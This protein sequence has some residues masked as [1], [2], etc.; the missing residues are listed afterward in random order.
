[1]DSLLKNIVNSID[2]LVFVKN[3][4]FEYIACNQAFC[5]FVGLEQNQIIGRTDQDI[6]QDKKISDWFRQWDDKLFND[7]KTQRVE[8][9]CQYPNGKEVLFDTIKYPYRNKANE[10]VALVG[11]SRDITENKQAQEQIKQLNTELEHLS[12]HD[13]LT[14]IKN[15]RYFDNSFHYNLEIA[16]RSK[17]QIALVVI[18]VDYFKPF[19]DQYGH[20]AGDECLAKVAEALSKIVQRKSDL[21]ARYGGDEFILLLQDIDDARLEVLLNNCL[22]EVESLAIPH[23]YSLVSEH[24]SITMGAYLGTPEINQTPKDILKIADAALYQAK[25]EGRNTF[26]IN[27]PESKVIHARFR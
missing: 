5:E 3:Q 11:I 2:D 13:C 1:M 24:V 25:N 4:K 19:N 23:N 9:W 7:G 14:H 18:D 8:E 20:V 22:H 12:T 21:V 26:T 17:Q 15:R 27:K 10:V 16:Q 6:F